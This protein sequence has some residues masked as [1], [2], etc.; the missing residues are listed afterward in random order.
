MNLY[1]VEFSPDNSKLYFSYNE[2]SRIYQYDLTA[3]GGNQVAIKSSKILISNTANQNNNV[4][5]MQL[6]PDGKIYVANPAQGAFIIELPEKQMFSLFI[7]DVTGRKIYERKN[8]IG[9]V[10][11]DCSNIN[12]G[13]YFV[14]ASNS[15]NML[16]YKLVKE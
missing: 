13:I 12:S 3:G 15:E 8:A 9:I 5:G 6:D 2:Y 16:T 7:T 11:V 10:K 4:F 1:G 14:Q